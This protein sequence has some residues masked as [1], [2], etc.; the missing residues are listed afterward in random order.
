MMIAQVCAMSLL[1]TYVF[2]VDSFGRRKVTFV[3]VAH[4]EL[5]EN[6][7]L[8]VNL[9]LNVKKEEGK[10][11]FLKVIF[12]QNDSFPTEFCGITKN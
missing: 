11:V 2:F 5:V 3:S 10:C 9:M 7:V 4:V 8:F 12:K 6:R 1:L